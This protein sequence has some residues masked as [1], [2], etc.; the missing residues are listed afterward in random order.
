MLGKGG[1]NMTGEGECGEDTTGEGE[2]PCV[3]IDKGCGYKLDAH[4]MC[5]R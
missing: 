5:G 1:G 3:D 4:I 2:C